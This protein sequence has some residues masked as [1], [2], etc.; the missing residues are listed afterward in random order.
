MSYVDRHLLP[1]ESVRYRTHLHWK[2]Y[3]VPGLLTLL[4]LTPLA[5]LAFVSELKILGALPIVA[6]VILLGIAW[7]QRHSSEFAVTDRR[8]IVK[9]GVLTTRSIELLIPKVEGI[10]VTQTLLGRMLGYGGIVVTGSGGTR[11]TFLGI[12]SPLDFR[13]AVQAAAD[14]GPALRGE[15][16]I[17][18]G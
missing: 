2:V 7:L 10:A 9:L 17:T 6:A 3:L 5:V 12:Q 8:V 14:A 13:Q 1:G 16:Q 11:E 15:G 18:R 4:V